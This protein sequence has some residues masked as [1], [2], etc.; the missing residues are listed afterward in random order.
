MNGKA[1]VTIVLVWMAAGCAGT[2]VPLATGYLAYGV[3]PMSRAVYEVSDTIVTEGTTPDGEA[4]V[5]TSAS[6]ATLLLNFRSSTSVSG[7]VASGLGQGAPLSVSS[8]RMR[9]RGDVRSFESTLS[10]PAAGSVFAGLDD[11]SGTLD[12]LVRRRGLDEQV[13]APS[14]PGAPASDYLFPTLGHALFPRMPDVWVEPGESWVDTVTVADSGEGAS[15]AFTM[16]R[17]HTLV[18]DTLVRGLML[19]HIAVESEVAVNGA[20]D[21][22]GMSAAANVTGTLNG[23]LLWDPGRRLVAYA[24]YHRDWRATATGRGGTSVPAW[25]MAGPTRIWRTR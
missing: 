16:I 3:P 9:V 7:G 21:E 12:L 20:M 1:A 14:V 24:E 23:S 10:S 2:G 11:V 5:V 17:T 13:S 8:G 22:A 18:G 6:S 19:V 4:S 15:P 25:T